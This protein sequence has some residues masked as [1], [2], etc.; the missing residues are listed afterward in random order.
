MTTT[1]L[2]VVNCAA[3]CVRPREHV[4]ACGADWCD[5]ECA[6][7]RGQPCDVNGGCGHRHDPDCRGCMP[8]SSAPGA[9]VCLACV[10]RAYGVLSGV[11]GSET[12]DPDRPSIV[13]LYDEC[14]EPARAASGPR[15]RGG[16]TEARLALADAPRWSREWTHGV[17]LQ[18]CRI[19]A[20]PA[21][22]GRSL[23]APAR[24]N[25]VKALVVRLLAH[26]DW[27][28]AHPEHADQ[29]VHDLRA[30]YR[31]ALATARP[32]GPA[33][34]TL[35]ACPLPSTDSLTGRLEHALGVDD[36]ET[37]RCGAPIR[38]YPDRPLITCP[39]CGT[40]ADPWWW[41]G[42]LV[43]PPPADDSAGGWHHREPVATAQVLA[44][45]LSAE[46]GRAVTE[47]TIRDWASRG[48]GKGTR[49]RWLERATTIGPDLDPHGEPIVR[50]RRE[51][52]RV[53]YP[54]AG[55]HEFA[56]FVYRPKPPEPPPI[57]RQR[58]PIEAAATFPDHAEPHR[59]LTT[60]TP[61]STASP[62]STTNGGPPAPE[63]A[64]PRS[65]GR[66]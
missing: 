18:W 52:S 22:S 26:A 20:E 10:D 49:K 46:Y 34:I 56:E 3:G 32:Q 58:R 64:T 35:G 19:L 1:T 60:T 63:T 28:L 33:G 66:S 39:G 25:T 6:C 51:G 23:T 36:P 50:T 29:F 40:T 54:V 7:H 2:Y 4:S 13:E 8:A 65:R 42:A 48:A 16:S 62:A 38:A 30:I 21:P 57:P 9:R 27:I 53:L 55:V 43:D 47:H 15:V 59:C 61:S 14:A 12:G 24:D 37:S 5:V 41:R 17:L 45:W 11:D 31:D 44:P